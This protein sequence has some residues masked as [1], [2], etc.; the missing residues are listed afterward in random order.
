MWVFCWCTPWCT[1]FRASDPVSAMAQDPRNAIWRA[2][3][4]GVLA[5]ALPEPI[6]VFRQSLGRF[7]FADCG[8][9]FLHRGAG[10]LPDMATHR[11]RARLGRVDRLSQRLRIV[12]QVPAPVKTPLV[13]RALPVVS[14]CCSPHGSYRR[15]VVQRRGAQYSAAPYPVS[16]CKRFRGVFPSGRQRCGPN[17]PGGMALPRGAQAGKRKPGRSRAESTTAGG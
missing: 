7:L 6:G 16:R 3:P 10:M 2:R 12:N 13:L 11:A 14:L 9:T 8:A 17:P 1:L 5:S 15:C 4:G